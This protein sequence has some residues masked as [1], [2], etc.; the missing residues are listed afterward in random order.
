[1]GLLFLTVKRPL[2]IPVSDRYNFE[3]YIL[4]IDG[5]YLLRTMALSPTSSSSPLRIMVRTAW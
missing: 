1:M 3:L 5:S 2:T 4:I